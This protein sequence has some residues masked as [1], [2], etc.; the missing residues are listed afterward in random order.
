[1][2]RTVMPQMFQQQE[3]EVEAA[4]SRRTVEIYR[5]L[6]KEVKPLE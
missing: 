2:F 5:G 1:V 4:G 6:Q 3:N